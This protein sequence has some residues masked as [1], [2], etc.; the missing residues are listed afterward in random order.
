MAMNG[1]CPLALCALCWQGPI[2]GHVVPSKRDQ[3]PH[4]T[5]KIQDFFYCQSTNIRYDLTALSN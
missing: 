5:Q 2:V 3:D 4:L 1:L